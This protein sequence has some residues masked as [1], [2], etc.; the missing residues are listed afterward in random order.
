MPSL[1]H[2]GLLALIRDR[3]EFAAELLREVLHVSVPEFTEARIAEASFPEIVPTEFHADLV[4]LLVDDKPVFGIVHEAQLQPKERKRFTWPMY[5][6]SLRARFECPVVVVVIA[7][8]DATARWA[9]EPIAL[10]GA[11][12][13]APFVI[14]PEGVPIVTDPELAVREPELALL[15]MMA[16]GGDDETIALAVAR[17]A[18]KGIEGFDRERWVLYFGLIESSLSDAARKAFQMLPEGQQFFSESQ[19]QSFEQGSAKGQ[20]LGQAHAILRVLARRN[21]AVSDEQRERITA[22]TD[23]EILD[24]WLDR[25]VTAASTDEL[26]KD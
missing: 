17:A 14:G 1:L 21:I 12:T 2:E 15:S 10:G 6:A 7:V 24:R 25:A 22:C 11:S 3:P 9:A 18:A 16:H 26:F 5:A 4:V 20:A 19:R 8:D 13:F 23:A